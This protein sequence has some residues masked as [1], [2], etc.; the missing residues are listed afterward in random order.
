MSSCDI[1]LIYF[2]IPCSAPHREGC[3]NYASHQS[4]L[5]L[6]VHLLLC[7]FEPHLGMQFLWRHI[8]LTIFLHSWIV[9]QY[10]SWAKPRFWLSLTQHV[11]MPRVSVLFC[12]Q[13]NTVPTFRYWILLSWMYITI[14]YDLNAA[15]NEAVFVSVHLHRLL[16]V[17]ARH[18]KRAKIQ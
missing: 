10:D 11:Y 8:L 2:K 5:V 6:A 4:L 12:L 15:M 7:G 9:M 14:R 13:Q 3:S 16:G 17:T 18:A 1:F